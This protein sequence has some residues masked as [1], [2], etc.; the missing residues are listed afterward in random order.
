[1]NSSESVPVCLFCVY[2]VSV[3]GHLLATVTV[4]IQAHWAVVANYIVSDTLTPVEDYSSWSS[5]RVTAYT[6][7]I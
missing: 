1:M 4:C 2:T 7:K 6:Q 3:P 5:I